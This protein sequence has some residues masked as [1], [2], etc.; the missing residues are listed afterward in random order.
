MKVL[1][2]CLGNICRSPLAHGILEQ[3]IEEH[4]L[5][6][7]VDSCGTS[8]FH[9][10]ELPDSRS[11]EVAKVNG[12]DITNQRSRKLISEDTSTF[13]LIIAMDQSNYNDIRKIA[14]SSDYPKIRMLLNYSFPGENRKVPDPYYEG[15]FEGVYQMIYNACRLL[16][17]EHL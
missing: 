11:I 5:D 3:M 13:D 8:G 7:S 17:V 9:N 2:V 16:I 10:G 15:D 6:W 14:T 12:L 4:G 1:M